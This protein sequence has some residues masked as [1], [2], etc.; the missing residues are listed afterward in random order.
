MKKR[1]LSTLLI[2][3]LCLSLL[4]AC[5]SKVVTAEEAQKIALD[6]AGLKASDVSDMHTHI[7][8]QDGIPCF[9]IHIT[10][11]AGEFSY[12]IKAEGGEIL[13]HGEGGHG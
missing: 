12:V 10:C 13:E 5:G 3:V 4:A 9:N 6:H 11:E 7:I 8:E 1:L 2:A